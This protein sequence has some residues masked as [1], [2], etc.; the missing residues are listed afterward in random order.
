[1]KQPRLQKLRRRLRLKV[2]EACVQPLALRQLQ[3]HGL[4]RHRRGFI[5]CTE[6]V[7]QVQCGSF[8][9]SMRLVLELPALP[10]QLSSLV[11]KLAQEVFYAQWVWK[12]WRASLEM[13]SV[14]L[15]ERSR[16]SVSSL[17]TEAASGTAALADRGPALTAIA[18]G[19]RQRV[20]WAGSQREPRQN[21]W[22]LVNRYSAVPR[23]DGTR[24]M[25]L[26][27]AGLAQSCVVGF[28]KK[29]GRLKATAITHRKREA[30][31][32]SGIVVELHEEKWKRLRTVAYNVLLP[33]R[34]SRQKPGN[35]QLLIVAH[36]AIP[37][38]PL[39]LY[40]KTVVF[41]WQ[42]RTTCL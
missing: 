37:G 14:G 34:A 29:K 6:Q 3:L 21:E 9:A 17:C 42:L 20:L 5:L 26:C 27:I 28:A 32:S 1:M 2:F 19:L 41:R 30:L 40:E 11:L 38:S 24:R 31:L 39:A 16:T 25:D 35:A 8:C 12:G 22:H 36:D 23:R 4:L 18:V 7:P 15:A 13:P 10:Q 33:K